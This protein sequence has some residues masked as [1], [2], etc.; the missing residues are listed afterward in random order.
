MKSIQTKIL[1][2]IL[3]VIILCTA[4]I[5][6][7][8]IYFLQISSDQSTTQI[9]NLICQEE[10]RKIDH[11]FHSIEQSVKILTTNAVQDMNVV[12]VL[13]V[14]ELRENYMESLRPIVLATAESA[15]GAVAAY[16]HFNPELAPPDAGL[17]YAKKNVEGVFEEQPP[18]DFSKVETDNSDKIVWYTKPAKEGKASWIGPYYN[19]KSEG[20]ILT[21]VMPVYSDHTLVGVAGMDI[22]MSELMKIVDNIKV[23]ERFL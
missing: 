12:E 2:L 9:M 13:G 15:D 10:G 1:V 6:G 18:T 8:S 19:G 3:V 20:L 7:N 22:H 17:F 5:G 16:I 14:K 21:Y 23:Y 4:I 11:I